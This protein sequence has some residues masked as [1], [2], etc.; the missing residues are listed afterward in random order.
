MGTW[1]ARLA[2]RQRRGRIL[3]LPVRARA[4][5]GAAL[6]AIVFM[7]V[8]T[9][10]AGHTFGSAPPP[11]APPASAGDLA[12]IWYGSYGWHGAYFLVDDGDCIVRIEEDATFTATVTPSK[13]ANNIAKASAWSGTVVTRR[14]R[15]TFKSS[16]G[17][18]ITLIR[19]GD[20]LYGGARD[21]LVDATIM[22]RLDRLDLP[23]RRPRG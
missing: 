15:V 10:C 23:H 16:Q 12:G 17:P 14:D 6:A 20:T 8:V 4:G 19:S 2:E 9:G 1:R 22:I 5:P 13:G 7:A 21:P 3:T 18:W 11:L